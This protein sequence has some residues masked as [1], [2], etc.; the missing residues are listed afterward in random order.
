MDCIPI[1]NENDAVATDG[2]KFGD[3]DTLG[4]FVSISIG[5]TWFFILTDVDCLFTANPRK[6]ADAK[7]I[8]YVGKIDKL[9]Q[10]LDERESET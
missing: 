2:L 4:A 3:N 9:N 8:A 6:H 7:P 10:I 5:A 1:I